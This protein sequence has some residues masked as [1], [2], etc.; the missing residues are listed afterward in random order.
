MRSLREAQRALQRA[1]VDEIAPQAADAPRTAIYRHAYRARLACALRANYPALASALGD[2]RFQ[3]VAN[4]YARAH[5]SRHYSIR[6]HGERLAEALPD[7]RLGDLARLEWALDA[8][9]DAADAVVVDEAFLAAVP[10]ERW[11]E[12][13]LAPHP[14]VTVLRLAWDVGTHWKALR[15]GDPSP[16]KSPRRHPHT[17]IAWRKGQDARWRACADREARALLSLR[18]HRTLRAL[19]RRADEARARRIGEWFAGWV[20]EGLLAAIPDGDR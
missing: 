2:E 3:R 10:L 19:C 1:I 6:W 13:A 18:A 20:R 17:I 11:E 16:G 12:V 5:P 14:S 4:E 15:A 8:A 9:F 7:G